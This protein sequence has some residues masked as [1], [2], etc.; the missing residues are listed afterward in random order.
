[1]T[2]YVS[3]R[4]VDVLLVMP[5]RSSAGRDADEAVPVLKYLA[6]PYDPV[7]VAL[8]RLP[9]QECHGVVLRDRQRADIGGVAAVIRRCPSE[10]G[11]LL[12]VAIAVGQRGQFG[13]EMIDG[14][15]VPR[16]RRAARSSRQALHH[17][18]AVADEGF[19]HLAVTR[20]SRMSPGR[21]TTSR[22]TAASSGHEYRP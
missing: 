17:R 9:R 3:R 1:M 12:S 10:R 8:D 7:E 15:L 5:R 19:R 16:R 18:F 21:V 4:R 13:D 6:V 20:G 22:V 11:S 14:A 2:V